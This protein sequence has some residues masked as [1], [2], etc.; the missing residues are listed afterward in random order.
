MKY[1]PKSDTLNPVCSFLINFSLIKS[2]TDLE[3]GKI[4]FVDFINCWPREVERNL[5]QLAM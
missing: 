3:S 1:R 5:V 4:K 2:E